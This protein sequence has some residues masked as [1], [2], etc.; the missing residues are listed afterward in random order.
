MQKKDIA[1]QAIIDAKKLREV[2]YEDAKK[3]V[4][5]FLRSRERRE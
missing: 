5:N 1:E 3:E 2:F 4:A